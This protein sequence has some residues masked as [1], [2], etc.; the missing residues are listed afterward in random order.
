MKIG[1]DFDNTISNY[2]EVLFKIA[3]KKKIKIPN[4]NLF[5]K[6]F[7]K[8]AILKKTSSMEEWK[9]IQSLIYGKLMYEAR[10]N[11]GF[12]NFIL[13]C[14]LK[15]Y[16]IFIVS[17]KTQ[18]AH[19]DKEKIDLRKSS[20]EW[21]K[22]NKFF[23]KK[24]LNLL[25][26]NIYF[27]NTLTDKIKRIKKIDCD[28][29]IDDLEKVFDHKLFPGNT[30]KILFNKTY[31]DKR[32]NYIAN[33]WDK[34]TD[35]FHNSRN[36][37]NVK[38]L[39]ERLSDLKDYKIEK[40]LGRANSK[41]YKITSGKKKYVLKIY[42]N[43][44]D[45]RNRLYIEFNS[46]KFLRKNNI[47]NVP[48][49]IKKDFFFNIALYEYLEGQEI[50]RPAKYEI[51]ASLK[52]IKKLHDLYIKNKKFNFIASESYLN[53]NSLILNIDERIEI[54]KTLKFEK[55][56]NNFIDDN[57]IPLWLNIRKYSKLNWPLNNIN[58]D[59]EK[60][61]LT[62]SPSDF[63]FHNSLMVKN[64]I[65][66]LDFEYFGYDDPVKTIA[67]FLWH[68]AMNI[69]KGN[70]LFWKN[71][72]FKIFKN[73]NLLNQRFDAAYPVYGVR[74]ISIMLKHLSIENSHIDNFFSKKSIR[75]QNYKKIIDYYKSLKI[76]DINPI[77]S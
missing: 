34:I 52:F 32:Y 7:F 53:Y 61:Y 1:I 8:K 62:Y 45:K 76:Y 28:Y 30:K 21:M 54:L 46:F 24:Y 69:S 68:P 72:M 15:E 18:F 4:Q 19:Y 66:F 74:W 36:E 41:V 67:D 55:K 2:D 22:K 26:E 17:H 31:H 63:G 5:N 35:I 56:I 6:N 59:L 16:E 75:N 47:Y 37:S 51:V 65:K 29:F 12:S 60:I 27:E 39:F 57:L 43:N 9:K 77:K 25:S 20:I 40:F 73:D 23:N 70:Y 49:P 44:N 64:K 42:P 58:K 11:R 14:K 71:E 10:I 13:L 33:T 50:K 48:K 3:L 38:V